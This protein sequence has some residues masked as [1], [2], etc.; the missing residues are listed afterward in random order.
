MDVVY[1][2]TGESE[3]SNFHK[4]LPGYYFRHTES[5]GFSNGSGTGNETASERSMMRKFMVD[6][7]VFWATEYNLSGFRF[8]LMALHDVETMNAISNALHEIDPTII[9]Y[10]E[11]WNGGSTPLPSS[12]AADK[13]NIKNLENVGAFN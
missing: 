1:N 13:G 4:I 2:H 3:G 5:G 10:G 8:D 7:T 11:P 9:V 6:S 12:L